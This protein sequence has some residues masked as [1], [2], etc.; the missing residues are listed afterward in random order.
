MFDP[1]NHNDRRS[2]STGKTGLRRWGGWLILLV[3][4]VIG[5]VLI[6]PDSPGKPPRSY[7]ALLNQVKAGNVTAVSIDGEEVTATF[8]SPVWIIDGKLYGSR[9]SLPSGML[10][11]NVSPRSTSETTVP[12]EIQSDFVKLLEQHDV[13]IR[14][15]KAGGS[16]LPGLSVLLA[17]ILPLL[18][19][20]AVVI[21]FG[22][23]MSRSQDDVL[24]FARTKARI[25]DAQRPRV[26]FSD[27]AGEDEAKE[28]LS[29]VVDFLRY[30]GKYR[31]VGAR[32]P[33]G[34]LLVGPP[35]TGKTLLARAVAGEAHVPFFSVS[36]SQF[37][38]MFVGVGASRVRD[39][40]KQAKDASPAIVY[41]D[42]LDAVG[43]RRG[44]GLGGGSDE[45]EQTL[46]QLLV[47]LDGFEPSQE[48]IVL[49]A[50][51]R[52]DVLDPALLRPG[53]FDRQVTLG[54]PDR[55]GRA[56]IL[57][58]HSRH[59]PLDADVDLEALAA[60]TPGF[61]GAD[62]A[63]LVN[64][65]AL[66][67]AMQNRKTV[68]QDNF[69]LAFDRI[70][71]GA[72]RPL[73]ISEP[74]RQVIAF[75]EAGHAIVAHFTPGA[76]PLHKISI[77][78]RGRSLGITMQAPEEERVNYS[79][80]YLLGRLAIMMGGRMAEHLVFSEVTTGA[81][82]DLKEAT[83]TARRMVGLWGMSDDIGPI[84]LGMGE[85]QAFLGGDMMDSSRQVS[86]E[87]LDRAE[88]AMQHLL[89]DAADHARQLLILHRDKLDLLAETLL[90]EE[91]IDAEAVGALIG[92]RSAV[93]PEPVSLAS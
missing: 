56:E 32:L 63:N 91:T 34:V 78:A 26:T 92:A 25:G 5:L 10:A 77:V 60:M 24:G 65:A 7:S 12:K 13:A 79:R 37:V 16:W 52:P 2:L 30:P 3:G 64:E 42:E 81:E 83:A 1:S 54:L 93:A 72:E 11:A 48:V 9:A 38:E 70:V 4:V 21:Y 27:V 88:S 58:L 68:G 53:R 73:L 45:R 75:H 29:Q 19:V 51:N 39:L 74:Q 87:M 14:I 22:R 36:A 50:T 86:Q 41:V 59:I 43:R 6:W 18:I 46:N 35:G 66:V 67:A 57:N 28:Q 20:G 89:A 80:T 40:F 90:R 61:S 69:D 62:L 44:V 84:F 8:K 82:N 17:A 15:E 33:H 71:L 76:D 49:A 23:R 85:Q 31:T 47:E 55:R